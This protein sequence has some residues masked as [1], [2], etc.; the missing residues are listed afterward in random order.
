MAFMDATLLRV[1][2]SQ[3]QRSALPSAGC[4]M[5]FTTLPAAVITT[6]A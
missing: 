1:A 4:V 2:R 5:S 6:G 3:N